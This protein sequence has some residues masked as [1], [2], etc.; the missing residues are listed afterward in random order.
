MKEIKRKE[1]NKEKPNMKNVLY[2][3]NA[4]RKKCTMKRVCNMKR[5][6]C[7]ESATWKKRNTKRVQHKKKWSMKIA[8]K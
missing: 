7:E 4:I 8:L 6:Q 2:N 1:Y 5:V 3:K